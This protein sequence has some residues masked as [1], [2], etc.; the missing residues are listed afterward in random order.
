MHRISHLVALAYTYLFGSCSAQLRFDVS[1]P[2]ETRGFSEL[3]GVQNTRGLLQYGTESIGWV[4]GD[5]ADTCIATCEAAGGTCVLSSMTALDTQEEGFYVASI[6]GVDVGDLNPLGE[7]SGDAPGVWEGNLQYNGAASDCSASSS[8]S[9][10][11]C[12]CGQDCP[13]SGEV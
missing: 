11:F 2:V 5:D 12:C 7:P 1:S 13:L 10:R 3:L 4:L 8:G 6:L 9:R